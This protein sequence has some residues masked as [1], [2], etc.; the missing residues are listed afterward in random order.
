[1][2]DWGSGRGAWASSVCPSRDSLRAARSHPH[3]PAPFAIIAG[4][5]STTRRKLEAQGISTYLHVPSPGLLRM[6][7]KDGARRFVFE[8]KS[9]AGTSARGLASPCGRR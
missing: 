7:L 3:S 2:P 8:G 5:P 4:E 6:F 1:M 9:V